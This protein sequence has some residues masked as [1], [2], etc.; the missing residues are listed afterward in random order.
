MSL[1]RAERARY[2]RHLSLPEIGIDGQRKLKAGRV[3]LIGMGGLGCPS[4]L[5]LAAAGVGT[6]GLV[7]DDVVE[8]SNLQRQVLYQTQ[9]VGRA[10]VDVARERLS[11]LNPEIRIDP[12]KERLCA[13]NVRTLFERYH[14]V[15]DGT[16][17]FAIRYLINDACVV[18]RRPFVS[19][20]IHRFQ[21]Q[22][23]TFIPDRG[24]CYRCLF[25]EPPAAD[26]VPNC[27][28]AG[29]LGVLP[30]VLGAMQA[31]E[32][33]KWLLGCGEPLT[34]RLLRY[35]AL[36]MRFTELES[37]RDNE[38]PVCGDRPTIIA[39]EETRSAHAA[40]VRR[41]HARELRDL[42]H[43]SNLTI[44]DVR[45]PAEFAEGHIEGSINI[46]LSQLEH[47]AAGLSPTRLTVFV[48]RS[49]VRS[50]AACEHLGGKMGGGLA[51][52]EG[53]LIAWS[54]EFQ[55]DA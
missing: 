20:A 36:T 3:L 19:A 14:I 50:F 43:T 44:V 8:L 17:R 13:T 53:G 1:S 25:A 34:G 41:I 55:G 16:D 49:G 40:A 31:T 22:L 33:I 18:L 9:D 4:A 52:L 38:C 30:G 39:P 32:A 6:L 29:V 54:A 35:H 46:P 51:T 48:C 7:D 2:Q 27:A 47:R 37:L 23:F 5:Y 24:A 12:F 10:K 26:A 28:D 15:L 42:M 11:A 21:G 45:E